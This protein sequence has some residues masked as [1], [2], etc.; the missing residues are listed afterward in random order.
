MGSKGKG[1]VQQLR[2]EVELL[3]AQLSAMS[4]GGA[5]SSG[6]PPPSRQPPRQQQPSGQGGGKGAKAPGGAGNDAHVLACGGW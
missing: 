6:S 4:C 3:Q 1:S 2:R 5:G